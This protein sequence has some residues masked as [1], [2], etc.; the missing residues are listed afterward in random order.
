[1]CGIIGLV[2]AADCEARGALPI[3][4]ADG[5]TALQHRGTESAG[6]V[7]SGGVDRHAFDIV[8]GHGLVREI[9]THEAISRLD[10]AVIVMGHNR[11]STAGKKRPT[12]NCVQP[13]VV[14]TA[15]GTIAIAHNGE[16]VG[17]ESKRNEALHQGVGLS[18][19]TDSELIA[20]MVAKAVA[21][22]YKCRVNGDQWGD[23]SK[24]LAVTMSAFKT[25]YSLLV[26]TYDRLYAIRDPWGNRPLCV[27][28]IYSS[29]E[30]RNGTSQY[31]LGYVAASESCALPPSARID[32][33]VKPGEIVEISRRGI[34]SV[35][36]MKPHNPSAFC[37]FEYVYF[38]RGDTILEGQQ[39]QSVRE[40][41]GRILAREAPID[42][43]IVS[44]VP[45]SSTA[46]AI[47]Y[48]EQSGIPYEPSLHR[49]SYV[50]RSFIQP[51]TELRQS[52]ILR[53]FGV[54]KNNVRDRRI[55]LVDDSIVRGNTM[56]IIVKMLWDAGAKEVHLRIASPPLKYPCFMGINIPSSK[57][58]I[59]ANKTLEEMEEMLGV[60]SLRYLSVDGLKEAVS[61]RL[62]S[63][64]GFEPGHCTACLTG[65]YPVKLDF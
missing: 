56:G 21:L 53:K 22:N 16:L 65:N 46:A 58:L 52:A 13:F 6:L 8:K 4:A 41:T 37:I 24:E 36:Q 50:G 23:I 9:F 33:E 1:M 28:T 26:M 43:D 14:Y 29:R 64:P 49:N 31:A 57:E 48:A 2:Q 32:M 3:L 34:R 11:Y 30:P 15:I 63:E 7:G 38:A 39:V 54:L 18:T 42:A 47:G 25:S 51:N 17:A 62:H 45:D 19:D 20:Q 12:I 10:D 5:L 44:N 60:T 61:K 35:Y 59:A 55:V 27:G 40:E